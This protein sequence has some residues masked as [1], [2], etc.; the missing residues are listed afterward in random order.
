MEKVILFDMDGVLMNTEPLHYAIWQQVFAE[1]GIIIDFERYKGCIGSTNA[2]L[3]ELIYEG[4]GAD[5]RGDDSLN[6]R[7]FQLKQEHIRSRGVPPI[8]GVLQTLTQLKARGYRMAVASSSPPCSIELCL[9]SLQ[10]KDFFEVI[11]SSEQVAR[12]KPAP[13]VFLAA[14][15]PLVESSTTTQSSGAA[16]IFSAAA[17]NTSGAG[18]VF[19][20]RSALKRTSKKWAMPARSVQSS[21]Y[22]CVEEE[23]TAMR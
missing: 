6:Q 4:Y 11:F 19:L 10:I 17:R 22:S 20:T 21:M 2:R 23:A 13:D 3:M 14:R 18:L 5:F 1:R 7:F 9:Q 15:V 16:P 12:P 8:D